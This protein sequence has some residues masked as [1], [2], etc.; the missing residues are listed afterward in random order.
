LDGVTSSLGIIKIT[1]KFMEGF[2]MILGLVMFYTWI[3]GSVIIA[4]K[5]EGLT[6]YDVVVLLAGGLFFVLFL[7]GTLTS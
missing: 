5:T 4:K 2:Y 1:N 3:H 7:V 6:T